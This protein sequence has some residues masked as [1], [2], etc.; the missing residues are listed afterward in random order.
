MLKDVVVNISGRGPRDWRRITN[1]SRFLHG[2]LV[3]VS[4]RPDW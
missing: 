3:Q 4:V 2:V 1:V